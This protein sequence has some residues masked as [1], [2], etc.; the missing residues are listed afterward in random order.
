MNPKIPDRAQANR[1][2]PR[3][4]PSRSPKPLPDDGQHRLAVEQGGAQ[5]P[6]E[7]VGQPAQVALR[8]GGVHPP[9]V[10]QLGDLL[11]GHGAQGGL[12]HVG[13]EGVQRGGGHEQ[14]G[15]QAHPQQEEQHADQLFSRES[16]AVFHWGW[17]PFFFGGTQGDFAAPAA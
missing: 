1:S 7:G 12:A 2:S 3:E 4:F 9:V 13:L 14:K 16:Q 17:A 11:L 15:R 10:L 6:V 8:Q 5:V